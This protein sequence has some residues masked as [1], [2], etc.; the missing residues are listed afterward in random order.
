ML[1]RSAGSPEAEAAELIFADADTIAD[2]YK[3]A[4]AWGVKNGVISGYGDNT[5]RPNQNISRAQMATFMYRYMKDAAGYDFGDVPPC[6]FEDAGEIAAPY[7]DAVN[8]VVSCGVMNGMSTAAFAPN[9]TANRGMAA[10]VILRVYNLT[11]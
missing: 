5:F 8:A 7:V 11:T 3:A 1:Y 4:V 6:D 2:S 9:N 10:T